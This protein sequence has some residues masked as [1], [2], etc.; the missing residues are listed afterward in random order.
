MMLTKIIKI[1]GDWQEVA[2]AEGYSVSRYGE[3][4]ND[5]TGRILTPFG[6]KGS[7]VGVQLGKGNYHR[8][9]RLVAEAFV[10]NP[11][12]KPQVNHKDGDK[13]NNC[14]DNL[15]WVTHSENQKQ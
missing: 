15:E 10:P 1:K 11:E 3:V 9:H 14:A 13:R 7:Y 2:C 5:V 8:V 6:P 4:R 12:N